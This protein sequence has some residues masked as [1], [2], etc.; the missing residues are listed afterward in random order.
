MRLAFHRTNHNPLYEILLNKRIDAEDR[1]DGDDNHRIF[2]GFGG[3]GLAGVFIHHVVE[4][5][6]Q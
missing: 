3:L 6:R 2:D 4:L 5:R 1:Q